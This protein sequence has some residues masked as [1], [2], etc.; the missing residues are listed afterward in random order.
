MHLRGWA[1]I[2]A[3]LPGER[4]ESWIGLFDCPSMSVV[5]TL[6]KRQSGCDSVRRSSRRI[7]GSAGRCASFLP[8]RTSGVCS[9]SKAADRPELRH[10]VVEHKKIFFPSAWAHYDEAIPGN[11]RLAPHPGRTRQLEEDYDKMGEMFF[12]E[13]PAFAEVLQILEEWETHFN[14]G[15]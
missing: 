3:R 14:Q 1:S 9:F 12:A 6:C 13:R 11:L 7:S 4:P 2:C 8:C 15:E 5:A 10:R